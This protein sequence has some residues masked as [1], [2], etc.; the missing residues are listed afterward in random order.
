VAKNRGDKCSEFSD[1]IG[2]VRLKDRNP[3]AK[4]NN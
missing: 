3:Q 1:E 4:V 2:M